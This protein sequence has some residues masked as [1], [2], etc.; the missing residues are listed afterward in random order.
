M[1]FVLENRGAE[2][3]YIR[4]RIKNTINE[5]DIGKLEDRILY[6]K[7]GHIEREFTPSE[8]RT[9]SDSELEQL[10]L[11]SIVPENLLFVIACAVCLSP[12]AARFCIKGKSCR[13]RPGPNCSRWSC[14]KSIIS[15]FQIV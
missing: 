9:L 10:G 1:A 5:L 11:R 7:E 12:K 2:P 6:M 4:K 15:C 8:F 14:R 3:E 13:K